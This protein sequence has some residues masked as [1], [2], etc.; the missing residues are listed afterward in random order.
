MPA[1]N[2]SAFIAATI[3]S[4][5]E[6]THSNLELIIIND[7]STDKT[8]D[9]IQSYNDV[10]IRYF[11]Q[12]NKGQCAASNFGITQAKGDYIKFFDADDL[13]NPQH[14]EAQLTKLNNRT[15]ALAS[16]AWG[17]FYDGNP[18]STRFSEEPV[19]RDM[20]PLQWLKASL[21]QRSDMMGAW[22]WLTPKQILQKAGGWNESLTLN[23]DFEFSTR[24]LLNAEDVLFTPDAKVFY[25]SG[26]S[27]SLS[28]NISEQAYRNAYQSTYLGCSY[29][30]AA[31]NSATMKRLC[32]NRYQEWIYR[33]YPNYPAVTKLFQQQI[34]LLGGSD[35]KPEGG[36]AFKI[37]SAMLGWK[38][39]KNFRRTLYKLLN[40]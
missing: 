1:Y 31:D 20:K 18:A 5:L 19:W 24:L 26:I 36:V 17:R 4:V 11:Y 21:S 37:L 30:L 23:N 22:L 7:G 16:C 9:V 6:Q 27:G 3:T 10:R 15:T 38:N 13:M 40:K 12:T 32:A 34:N 29:L 2:A 28:L 39:V 33:M 8:E 35:I 25:R 14:I